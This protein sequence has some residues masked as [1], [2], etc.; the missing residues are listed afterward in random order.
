MART[1]F[2]G[3]SSAEFFEEPSA[4][5]RTRRTPAE[6]S[7]AALPF[8]PSTRQALTAVCAASSASAISI[9]RAGGGCCA[10][11]W[12]NTTPVMAAN[13][14]ALSAASDRFMGQSSEG[15]WCAIELLKCKMLSVPRQIGNITEEGSDSENLTVSFLDF[16][17]L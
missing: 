11:C 5:T 1:A 8:T 7:T 13:A 14:N 6:S 4:D 15:F 9:P 3:L 12:A 17:G 10:G 16:V 2:L